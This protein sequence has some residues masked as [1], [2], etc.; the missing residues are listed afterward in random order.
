MIGVV[1]VTLASVLLAAAASSAARA[2]TGLSPTQVQ[3]QQWWITRL[4]LHKAWSITKGKGVTVAVLDSGVNAGFGDLR[5]AVVPGFDPTGTGDG[6]TDTD[7]AVHGTR[8]ADEIAGRGTG[9]GLLGVAP[10]AKIMPVII[11]THADAEQAMSSALDRIADMAHPPQVVNMSFGTE[12]PCPTSVRAATERA[13]RKGVIL[14][15]AAGNSADVT[16]TGY[17]ANC[18]GVIAIGAVDRDGNTWSD[19]TRAP[20][21]ALGGPGVK[22]IG[23]DAQAASG[24]GY[25]NGTSDAA[26]I[27]SGVFA[28]LRAHFPRASSRSL[29]S[30]ALYTAHQ[31]VGAPHSRNE[32]MGYGVAVPYK[33]L[34]EKV[35]ANAPNPI[36]DV[37]PV[38]ASASAPASTTPGTTVTAS[39][40]PRSTDASGIA[41]SGSG[42]GTN[43]GVI[44]AVVA[45]VVVIVAVIVLLMLRARR[46]ARH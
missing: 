31:F 35:P 6:T 23:Y 27:V 2:T 14:V 4:D 36:Y 39:G 38:E 22:L 12:A 32:Q 26:A 11:P 42:G 5:G 29:V 18:P 9:F 7:P 46:P 40:D 10:A 21:V 30:K 25:A 16:D 19:S 8:I 1:L 37:V 28:L 33:A 34:T 3:A 44:A 24:Y 43:V 13:V 41:D 20:Q 45:A 17:P 15:A